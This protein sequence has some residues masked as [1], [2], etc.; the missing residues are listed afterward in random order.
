MDKCL[1]KVLKSR[2]TKAY[3]YPILI[4]SKMELGNSLAIYIEYQRI[5]KGKEV[6]KGANAEN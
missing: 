6:L 4:L 2:L 1:E 3:L 5:N